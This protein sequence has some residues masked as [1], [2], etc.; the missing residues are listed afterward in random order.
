MNTSIKTM[1]PGI[2]SRAAVYEAITLLFDA[3]LQSVT[4][5]TTITTHQLVA[6]PCFLVA[7][8]CLLLGRIMSSVCS[9][10]WLVNALL[11]RHS[12]DL[13]AAVELARQ[14]QERDVGFVKARQRCC[15][16]ATLC[17]VCR[18]SATMAARRSKVARSWAPAALAFGIL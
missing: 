16:S 17:Q 7:T 5:G 2:T 14:A 1:E 12:L 15:I 10:G 9:L 18:S 3:V 4:C 11:V 8:N 13:S 6:V